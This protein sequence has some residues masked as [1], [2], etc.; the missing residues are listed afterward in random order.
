MIVVP[1]NLVYQWAD[2]IERVTKAFDVY[3]YYGDTRRGGIG[4]SKKLPRKI[5]NDCFLFDGSPERASAI[6][7]TSYQS[8][9]TRHGPSAL[10]KW[11]VSKE[12]WSKAEANKSAN[13]LDPKWP[14][15]LAGQFERVVLDEVHL[16]RN[17]HALSSV[18][19]GWLKASFN[20][21]LSATP[22][23][24][25]I[26]DFQGFVPLLFKPGGD[27]WGPES[28]KK[29]GLA[30]T[31]AKDINPFKLPDDHPGAVLRCT[32]EAIAKY[33]YHDSVGSAVAGFRLGQVWERCLIRRTFSSKLPFD[34]GQMIG[35]AIPPTMTKVYDLKLN[36]LERAKYDEETAQYYRKLMRPLP[37]GRVGWNMKSYRKLALLTTW[38]GFQYVSESVTAKDTKNA[39]AMAYQKTLVHKWAVHVGKKNPDFAV[40]AADDYFNQLVFLLRGSPRLRALLPIV[41]EQVFERKEKAIVWCLFPGQQVYVAAAMHL[42]GIDAK[43]FSADLSQREREEMVRSF[44]TD[45]TAT[46]VLV[47]SYSVNSSGMN[48]QRLCHNV[49]LFETAMSEPVA[50]QAIGRVR[51]LGQTHV[52]KV[53]DYRVLDS[54]NMRQAVTNLSKA[55]PGMIAELNKAIFNV[56][57]DDAGDNISLGRWERTDDGRLVPSTRAEED[58]DSSDEEQSAVLSGDDVVMTIMNIM[59]GEPL[60]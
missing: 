46:D 31:L 14:G 59:K 2:E 36:S 26:E 48:L 29:M 53:Y 57:I 4:S 24:N 58:D 23:F 54:F 60:R 3:V 56:G 43:I 52:V 27:L 39:A 34:D 9:T 10:Q 44:T 30:D 51:R 11:R 12:K 28:L 17:L 8:L 5:D 7:I 37:N 35:S 45:R 15:N 21:C 42:C 38:L 50:M 1:P 25:S 20:L 47:C 6:V 55:V 13:V 16:I 18:A 40:P 32:S 22:L 49:H 41:A 33:I 19:I